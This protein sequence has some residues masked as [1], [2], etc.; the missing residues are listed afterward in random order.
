MAAVLPITIG[1]EAVLSL[2]LVMY[3]VDRCM[4]CNVKGTDF[5]TVVLTVV[6]IVTARR[7][8]LF[9]RLDGYEF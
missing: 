9:V 1:C 5:G 8:S 3:F 2:S 6:I 4:L 7:C